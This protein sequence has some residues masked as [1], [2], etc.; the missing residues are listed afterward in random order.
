MRPI[1]ATLLAGDG[2]LRLSP[3]GRCT[4]NAKISKGRP[5]R[6]SLL[7]KAAEAFA[8]VR[9]RDEVSGQEEQQ[10][11]PD[12]GVD[13]IEGSEPV[14]GARVLTQVQLLRMRRT[15]ATAP[16]MST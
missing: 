4:A 13:G 1:N 3:T 15:F 6:P 2:G 5:M 8:V 16:E 10:A 7:E 11:H 14:A 12:R 9:S